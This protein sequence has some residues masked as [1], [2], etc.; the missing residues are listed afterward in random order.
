MSKQL[1][2]KEAKQ[3]LNVENWAQMPEEKVP[4]FISLIPYMDKDVVLAIVNQF[5]AY[6]SMVKCLIEELGKSCDA[7]MKENSA[8]Q[9]QVYSAYRK[10]LDDLGEIIKRENITE[11]ER[12]R[13]IDRMIDVADKMS[14]KDT[15]NK[16]FLSWLQKNKGYL[17]GGA[18]AIGGFFLGLRLRGNSSTKA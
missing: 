15:E 6:S 10:I 14:A 11:E 1:S 8:S 13:L 12:D 5:P 4:E 17:I 18:F 9:Q 2:E 7:A 3:K 16:G